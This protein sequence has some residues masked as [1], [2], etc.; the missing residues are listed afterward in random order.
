MND[1]DK[2]INKINYLEVKIEKINEDL[3]EIKKILTKEVKVECKKMGNHIDFIESIY[4]TV[5]YPLGYLCNK[6]SLISQNSFNHNYLPNKN[7]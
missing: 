2:I 7:N 4:E 6:I 5:K 1:I 3:Q